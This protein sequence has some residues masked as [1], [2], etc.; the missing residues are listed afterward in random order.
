MAEGYGML[1]RKERAESYIQQELTRIL[2]DRVHDPR[3]AGLTITEVSLTRDRRIARVYVASFSDQEALK[4]GLAGLDSAKGLLRRE[5]APLLHW[6]WVPWL[7][8]RVDTSWQYGERIDQLI[9]EL[10]AQSDDEQ[11]SSNEPGTDE[12]TD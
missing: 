4:D 1:H 12:P 8:F 6:P 2:R 9:E 11:E 3:V 10:H 7:E 5:L